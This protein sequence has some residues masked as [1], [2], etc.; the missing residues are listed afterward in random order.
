MKRL[1][2]G[3]IGI[4][5]T[6]ILM[7]FIVTYIITAFF[8]KISIGNNIEIFEA[9]LQPKNI[10][11]YV[12]G[13]DNLKV[14]IP[15]IP[16]M[17]LGIYLYLLRKNIFKEEYNDAHDFGLYGTAQWENPDKLRNGKV[18][19]NSK[20]STYK[21]DLKY[22]LTK[23]KNGY[24]LGKVPNSNKLLI[25][26]ESADV[27]NQNIAVIGSSGSS[28]SQ[29]YVIPNLINV[30]DKSIIVTD[31]KGELYDLTAQ[32]KKD[33]GYK[34]YQ[35]DF[36]SFMQSKYNP[37]SYVETTLQAQK[38][39][40]TII[41]NFEGDGGDN[42]F[43]K[44]SATNMLSALIIYVKAEFPP[45]EAN[46][47]KVV[48]IYTDYVQDETTF[49]KWIKTIHDEHPAKEMLNSII[50]LTGNTRGSV[51]STLNNGF[52]IFKLPQVKQMTRKSDFHFKDFIDE[53]AIL[54][55]KLS[56][57]D[58]T[59]APLT[60]V[61]FS[62]MINIYYDIAS[63][64]ENQKLKR[65]IVF[66]LDEFANIGKIDNYSRTLA[67][68]RSLGLSM[69]TIIQN[70][71]QLEKNSM[72]GSEETNDI[73]SNHDT[74]VLLRAKQEDTETTKWIS[75][76]LGT[77]TKEITKESVSVSRQGK[78]VSTNK[79]HIERPLMTQ[80]EVGSLKKHQ[81][82]VIIAGYNPMLLNKAMQSDIYQDLISKYD[83]KVGDYV[84]NYNNKRKELGFETPIMKKENHEVVEE[85]K[86]S[87]Y[88]KNKPINY[89]DYLSEDE[90][91][92]NPYNMENQ[93]I[94][95]IIKESNIT[96]EDIN[97][98]NSFEDV[99]KDKDEYK[100]NEEDALSEVT[101]KINKQIEEG[102]SILNESVMD[103]LESDEDGI[104]L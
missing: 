77:T 76:A 70:K 41:S 74:I 59:F 78:T 38:V 95:K 54:Y 20:E 18:L 66:M 61:F 36:I 5:I 98:M 85:Q 52:N 62:Q 68:C 81:S 33:Q 37:L 86:L 8:Y 29:S 88:Q 53:K 47:E 1:K 60:S 26:D 87:D 23:L 7:T 40:N 84:A 55:V 46:M 12:R 17:I 58:D 83:S 4:V 32:L 75:D 91:D 24:I 11:N 48:Q 3:W 45:E 80:A 82:I 102:E 14:I 35:V 27:S 15:F 44:N 101:E 16:L 6:G 69:H 65:K 73:L 19:A 28:K 10:Y 56:M 100:I 72:Y 97:K 99:Q 21:K 71:S 104:A 92:Q 9:L 79:E 94:N 103:L 39:A 2:S 22:N 51:T 63:E 64:S 90:N 93:I 43:F 42:V 96:K 49:K 89:Y 13:D 67:T 50:D 25:M 31:P 34:I 30:R 57:E